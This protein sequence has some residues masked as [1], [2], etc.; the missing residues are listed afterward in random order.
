ML[1]WSVKNLYITGI[2]MT[3][4]IVKANLKQKGDLTP[5]PLPRLPSRPVAASSS[6]MRSPTRQGQRGRGHSPAR[7]GGRGGTIGR[8][9][10]DRGKGH[11]YQKVTTSTLFHRS[12]VAS[13]HYVL[14]NP[15]GG[16]AVANIM[17]GHYDEDHIRPLMN[18][19]PFCIHKVFDHWGIAFSFFLS[20]YPTSKRRRILIS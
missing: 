19:V 2:E 3:A 10:T 1:K 16:H 15:A 7:Q 11:S 4:S 17:Q 20:Y 13:R 18:G 9:T 6:S 8:G 14:I 5:R 12:P